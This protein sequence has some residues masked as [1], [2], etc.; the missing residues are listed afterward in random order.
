MTPIEIVCHKGANKH[1][2][3]NTLSAARLCVEWGIDT[4]EVDVNSSLDGELFLF[5]GPELGKTTD[6]KGMIWDQSAAEIAR[7]D[8][9][10]WF[11]PQYAGERVPRLEAFLEYIRGKARVFFDVKFALPQQMVDIVRRYGMQDQCFFWCGDPRWMVAL[12]RAD[13]TLALKVNVKSPQDLE[14]VEQF[15]GARIVE[16]DLK[17]LTPELV[18]AC[19]KR[20]IRLMVLYLEHETE[21]F[22]QILA[23][24]AEMINT[25][26]GDEV[27]KVVKGEG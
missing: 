8:A 21:K 24:G 23:S 6:G 1:A 3:E 17:D 2:P 15:F 11:S 18:T 5:H 9:G 25:D 16:V 22:R 7:L 26:Y 13:P 19:K 10:S 27:L 4:V 12:R 14:R 20:G